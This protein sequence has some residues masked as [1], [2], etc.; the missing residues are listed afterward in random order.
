M[1]KKVTVA[2]AGL[3]G[4]GK[5]TY[6][7]CVKLF[8]EQMEIVAVADISKEKVEAV[9]AEHNIPSNM[10]FSSAEELIE[11]EKLADVLFLCTQDRQHVP[12][13]IPALKK[14]YHI[15]LEKPISPLLDE[16]R[17][18]VKVA[19]EYNR[20]V[21]VCHVLRYTPFFQKIKE[22]ITSGKIGE[23]ISIQAIENVAYWHQAHSFV[24]GNWRRADETS[25]MILAKCC[26]DM[27]I[28]IWLMDKKCTKVSSFGDLSFFK[29]DKAPKG[30]TAMCLGG[31]AVKET[32]PY[33]AEKIYLTNNH[34]GLIPCGPKWPNNIVALNPTTE[35]ITEALKTGPYGRCVFHCDNDV[36]DHQ[37]VNLE[38]E[39]KSTV[40]FTM[41]AFTNKCSRHIKVMGTMGEIDASME[42]NII[43]LSEF[44]KDS[45]F[46]DVNKLASDLSGHGGG[47]NRLVLDFINLVQSET[48]L[49]TALTSVNRSVESHF[50]ALAAEE[51]RLNGGKSIDLN[52]FASI[53]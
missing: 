28:L 9:A 33:D 14:G 15:L 18:I 50:I 22:I 40:N 20:Q 7:Q 13:A 27:D 6:A 16:C 44:G 36:V 4:R 34:T 11:Q 47:D 26:H 31:C 5:D 46:I 1:S 45:E 37:V 3:G 25:P 30:S 17:E 19:N 8:P 51:S 52:E 24:R 21:S 10:C 49:G 48:S 53:K 41:C 32:C 43:Q 12:Q 42:T 35:S 39:D 38:M 29:K 2:I 23:V